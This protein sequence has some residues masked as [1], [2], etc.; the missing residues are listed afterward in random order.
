MGDKKILFTKY[1]V[2]VTDDREDMDPPYAWQS[3][4]FDTVKAAVLLA[5]KIAASFGR[6]DISMILQA[7]DF[8]NPQWDKS[9]KGVKKHLHVDV[10]KMEYT[11]SDTYDIGL[12]LTIK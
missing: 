3:E 9:A 4:V 1:Y 11:S 5:R 12:E 8:L 6:S 2:E 7:G 10:M